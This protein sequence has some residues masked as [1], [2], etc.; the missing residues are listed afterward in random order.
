MLLVMAAIE[1]G[2][3]TRY[4]IPLDPYIFIF[5]AY[6]VNIVIDL[7]KSINNKYDECLVKE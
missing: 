6:A 2:T 3:V 5:T 1:E 4:R 7:A